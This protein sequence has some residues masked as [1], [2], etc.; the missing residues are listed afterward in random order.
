MGV[1]AGQA[2]RYP[3]Q[4]SRVRRLVENLVQPEL[5]VPS[6]YVEDMIDLVNDSDGLDSFGLDET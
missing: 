1:S 3:C 2:P 4:G 5:R 6:G